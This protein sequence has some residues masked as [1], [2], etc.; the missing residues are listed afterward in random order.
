[1]DKHSPLPWKVSQYNDNDGQWCVVSEGRPVANILMKDDPI[2]NANAELIVESV[3]N[4]AALQ[5][6]HAELVEALKEIE[7]GAGPYDQ[8]H[9]QHAKNTIQAMKNLAKE[10]LRRAQEIK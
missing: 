10:A 9:M 8:D 2:D 4:Y 1:M 3:N 7:I 5:A 6:S